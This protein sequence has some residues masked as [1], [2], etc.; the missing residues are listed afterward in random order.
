MVHLQGK[1]LETV[2]SQ[3]LHHILYRDVH[4]VQ[5]RIPMKNGKWLVFKVGKY[6]QDVSTQSFNTLTPGKPP[7]VPG[8]VCNVVLMRTDD[9][10]TRVIAR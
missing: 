1:H 10:E 4:G 6:T 5:P 9:R 8:T 2:V 7:N 3:L